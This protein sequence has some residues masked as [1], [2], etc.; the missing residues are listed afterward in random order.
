MGPP[1]TGPIPA[2]PGTVARAQ[3]TSETGHAERTRP[4]SVQIG[5]PKYNESPGEGVAARDPEGP[6]ASLTALRYSRH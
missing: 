3:L 1:G 5:D 2:R 6:G 4:L